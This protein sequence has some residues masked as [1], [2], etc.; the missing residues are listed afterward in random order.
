[1]I[2]I[3]DVAFYNILCI[4]AL[5]SGSRSTQEASFLELRVLQAVGRV[6]EGVQRLR[7]FA[8]LNHA[9]PRRTELGCF[10]RPSE[11]LLGAYGILF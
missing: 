7:L 9:V 2:I 8:E 1:M 5:N 4:E 10:A 6:A 3:H 11:L